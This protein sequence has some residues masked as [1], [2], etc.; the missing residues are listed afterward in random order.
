MKKALF[1]LA[2]TALGTWAA[3]TI[4]W[5]LT[6]GAYCS[7]GDIY[8]SRSYN[9][10][11]VT[12]AHELI[13]AHMGSV[14][15]LAAPVIIAGVSGMVWTWRAF[16]ETRGPD[17]VWGAPRHIVLAISAAGRVLMLITGPVLM[18]IGALIGVVMWAAW[19]LQPAWLL[20][21][22]PHWGVKNF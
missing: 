4:A 5:Q 15:L 6:A 19:L 1:R 17:V 16:Q 12:L 22:L 11:G 3:A 21:L 9:P 8:R 14:Y 7:H 20:Q 10:E 18:L 2:V 13:C